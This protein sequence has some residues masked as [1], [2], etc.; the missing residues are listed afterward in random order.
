MDDMDRL[1]ES[2]K[3]LKCN[4]AQYSNHAA[5]CTASEIRNLFIRVW[6]DSQDHVLLIKSLLPEEYK[7]M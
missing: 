3:D 2:L 7:I 6:K 4:A 1:I 5:E